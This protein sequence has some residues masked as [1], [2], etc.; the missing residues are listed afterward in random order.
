LAP[1]IP[2]NTPASSAADEGNPNFQGYMADWTPPEPGKS[3]LDSMPVPH[4]APVGEH[5]Q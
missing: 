5:R 4:G 2:S 1:A 3:M